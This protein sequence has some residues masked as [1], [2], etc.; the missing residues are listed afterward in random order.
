LDFT[1]NQIHGILLTTTRARQEAL[2]SRIVSAEGGGGGRKERD[3]RE[4]DTCKR[5]PEGLPQ[6]EVAFAFIKNQFSQN[7][8]IFRASSPIK[9]DK[10]SLDNQILLEIP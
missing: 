3:S 7:H 6:W 10:R 9:R 2:V 5:S 1:C 4:F 8:L